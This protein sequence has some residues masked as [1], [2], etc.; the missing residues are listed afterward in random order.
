MAKAVE[1]KAYRN[2]AAPLKA[3]EQTLMVKVT[4]P[5][6]GKKETAALDI[7]FVLDISGSMAGDRIAKMKKTMEFFV[8]EKMGAED[9][10]AIVPFSSDANDKSHAK[11]DRMNDEKKKK[12]V[13]AFING[14]KAHGDTN[15]AAGL[16]S[17]VKMLV[18][19]RRPD[20][21]CVI[22][23]LTD[24]AQNHGDARK[25]KDVSKVNVQTYGFGEKHD[26]TL[27][28]ELAHKSHG[29]AFHLVKDN[30]AENNLAD[31]FGMVL[32]RFR[33]ISVLNLRMIL[34]VTPKQKEP[35]K[36]HDVGPGS[37]PTKPHVKEEGSF[38][39]EFG[40]LAR[41]EAR[42]TMLLLH[43]P[44]VHKEEK[45]KTVLTVEC[46]YR[47]A[48]AAK[49]TKV[50]PQEVKM[51]RSSKANTDEIK[52]E[53]ELEL[54]RRKHA[55][56]VDEATKLAE[57]KNFAGAREKLAERLS[58]LDD[59]DNPKS[60]DLVGFL[61]TQMEHMFD[62]MGSQEE[63]D[64]KGKALA[65]SILSSHARQRP[66][67]QGHVHDDS[68][69]YLKRDTKYVAQARQFHINPNTRF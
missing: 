28:Y 24:G 39:V 36:I 11:L 34:R 68:L 41:L 57:K 49:D 29:G 4:A 46:S 33:D 50:G 43:L 69:F 5:A 8:K 58:A 48:G 52:P 42:R 61:T 18:E 65:L 40:D 47:L 66:T 23:L 63:Y 2:E 51:D 53:V 6:T 9:R 14:L 55:A 7:V 13:V 60:E 38:I 37:Y 25:V 32:G 17:A 31:G 19:G 45:G 35:E 44:K 26:P 16:E 67:V 62:H 20:R 1:I 27:L 30:S 15:I 12:A 59:L 64:K 3:H 54:F 21:A 56:A 22:F 10:L